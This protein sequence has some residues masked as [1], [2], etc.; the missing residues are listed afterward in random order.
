MPHPVRCIIQV[1]YCRVPNSPLD[2]DLLI[3]SDVCD[4]WRNWWTL[5]FCRYWY[6]DESDLDAERIA[7][8]HSVLSPAVSAD[9]TLMNGRSTCHVSNMTCV[10]GLHWMGLM[11]VAWRGMEMWWPMSTIKSSVDCLVNTECLIGEHHSKKLFNS[12]DNSRD[13]LGITQNN[14]SPINFCRIYTWIELWWFVI[15]YL[16]KLN[17]YDLYVQ[18][19]NDEVSENW[20]DHLGLCD[21]T[22]VSILYLLSGQ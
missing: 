18:S 5:L 17:L 15:S 12:I 11:R 16:R 7:H 10:N 22:H 9:I 4:G 2:N 21:F 3:H 14:T 1:L 20:W 19:K 6:L 8:F 13:F